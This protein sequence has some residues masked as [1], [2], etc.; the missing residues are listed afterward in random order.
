MAFLWLSTFIIYI[1]SIIVQV[2]GG[3]VTRISPVSGSVRGATRLTIFGEGFAESQFNYYVPQLGNNVTL[4][5]VTGTHALA[6]DVIP[7]YTN[8]Q[9]IVCNTRPSPFG[10]GAYNIR[11]QVDGVL[12][13]S[14]KGSTYCDGECVFKYEDNATP[15]VTSISP[16]YGVPGSVITI[17]G[18]IFTDRYVEAEGTNSDGVSI[19]RVF[20]GSGMCEPLNQDTKE[21]YGIAFDKY[22]SSTGYIKCRTT[23]T[24][25]GSHRVSFIVSKYGRSLMSKD[26]LL[27]DS[28]DKLY[29]F[30]AHAG[31]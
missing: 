6:C 27:V 3:R 7:Y 26:A 5:S 23:P 21:M 18:R 25:V 15:T 16:R 22:S 2:R 28:Q 29:M 31:T 24:T 1:F 30:Q 10:F 11:V 9:Q 12:L 14:I 20:A 17:R 19:L 8:R 4:I 13:R